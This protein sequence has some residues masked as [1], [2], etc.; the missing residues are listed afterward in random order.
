MRFSSRF[1]HRGWRTRAVFLVPKDRIRERLL[2]GSFSQYNLV[3]WHFQVHTRTVLQ[4]D[5]FLQKIVFL[6]PFLHHGTFLARQFV[7]FWFVCLRLSEVYSN[8]I[9]YATSSARKV[10]SSKK[11]HFL[12]KLSLWSPFGTPKRHSRGKWLFVL[13]W[14]V[15]LRLPE[16]YSRR[17][18]HATS[19]GRWGRWQNGSTWA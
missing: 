2:V 10:N 6:E 3:S 19:N 14:F 18:G 5:R 11:T 13:L 1:P 7:L 4:K 15:C 17:I 8:R 16:F 12:K 9:G